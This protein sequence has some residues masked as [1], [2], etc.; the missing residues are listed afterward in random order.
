[1]H[2][3]IDIILDSEPKILSNFLKKDFSK[4]KFKV[5]IGTHQIF[6]YR[7]VLSINDTDY[8]I[9]FTQL[10]NIFSDFKKISFSENNLQKINSEIKNL[11]NVIN[12][13]SK[14][15]KK[16][17]FI[18]WPL[19][20]SD[21]FLG[22]INFKT[23]G[24]NWIINYI[25]L[26]LSKE[27]SSLNNVHII[28]P[29]F[30]I[31]KH[32]KVINIFDYKLKYL[33]GCEYSYDYFEFISN[34]I[35]KKIYEEDK[36]KKIKLII[37]DLD[38]TLWG[39]L[40]GE[41][42]YDEVKV[43]P[44]SIEGQVYA[45]FQTRL[46][47]VKSSG[48]V[49]AIASKNDFK[50]VEKIFKRNNYMKLS[51]N[52]FSSTKVNWNRKDESVKQILKDLNLRSENT[53]FI[54]DNPYEREIVKKNIID[55]N[56]FD[57]PENILQLN[58]EFNNY[59]GLQKNFI[60]KTD[61]QRTKLYQVEKKRELTKKFYKDDLHWLKSL[62][63]KIKIESLKNFD[64]AEES[65]QRNNQ[66]NTSFNRF[67]KSEILKLNNLKNHLFFQVSMKDKFGDYGI[68]SLIHVVHEKKSF[69]ILDFTMSC[70]VFKRNVENAIFI[71][72]GK[73]QILKN[74]VGYI[75]ILRNDKNKYVQELFDKN[76]FLEKIDNKKF[77]ILNKIFNE[78][79]HKYGISLK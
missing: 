69:N 15:N 10:S 61:K 3:K 67:K 33:I 73:Q 18:L 52:D 29:N 72:L 77:R 4:K 66:F 74:K 41:V 2:K 35:S 68:I 47:L 42:N 39:G 28:D 1:M 65:F 30:M 19:D 54:D 13:Y 45:D 27:L 38:N 24:K 31:L 12:K 57:F 62:N 46:K 6:D 23:N 16:I 25:N 71:F 37:L 55:I 56:I 20:V 44:N 64:R 43:G 8:L 76:K 79:Y 48:I 63:I 14:K 50:N 60:S 59:L 36:I 7:Q 58:Q 75:N 51:L 34:L 22:D 5:K 40:A 26:N 53:L 32:Q 11:K 17:F 70:R 9:F 78:K 49:L 21:S